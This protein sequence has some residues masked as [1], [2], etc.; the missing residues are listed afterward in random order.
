MKIHRLKFFLIIFFFFASAT[1]LFAQQFEGELIYDVR[2]SAGKITPLKMYGRGD[3][4][5]MSGV[6]FE[7]QVDFYVT[8]DSLAM[9]FPNKKAGLMFGKD[10]AIAFF[11]SEAREKD[12]GTDT[13]LKTCPTSKTKTIS[14]FHCTC[15]E[16][17]YRS[18]KK[19]EF[20]VTSDVDSDLC[21]M[22][23]RSSWLNF[24]V[25]SDGTAAFIRDLNKSGKL[26]IYSRTIENNILMNESTLMKVAKRPIA[27]DEIE[28]PSTVNLM[29]VNPQFLKDASNKKK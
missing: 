23:F 28:V 21:M 14:G 11:E 29:R 22:F 24:W 19:R 6:M 5:K 3:H 16:A 25:P 27:D 7:T 1:S 20:W 26:I 15:I 4:A 13:L 9:V 12:K 8:L 18:G 10:S 17:N 2:D